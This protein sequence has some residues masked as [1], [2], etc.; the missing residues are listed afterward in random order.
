MKT[1][2][3]M[4]NKINYLNDLLPQIGYTLLHSLWGVTIVVL[5]TIG[6]I[7]IFKMT[8]TVRHQLA[9]AAQ[10]LSFLLVLFI[11]VYSGPTGKTT[12]E[13][14]IT[15]AVSYSEASGQ[16]GEA[17][18]LPALNRAS[19][20][21]VSSAR[22][23]GIA[24]FVGLLLLASFRIF[25]YCIS[26][27]M[28]KTGLFTVTDY[29]QDRLY[30]LS[31]SS[32]IIRKVRIHLSTKVQ[33]PVLI[34]YFKP[35]ILV[36]LGFFGELS[37]RE[38]ESILLHELAHIKRHDYLHLLIQQTINMLLFY[39]PAI[40]LLSRV[41]DQERENAC[42]D[43]VLAV[44]GDARTYARALGTMQ[45]NYSKT[46]NKMAMNLLNDKNSVL[47]RLRRL[48]GE[49]TRLQWS[50]RLLILPALILISGLLLAFAPS[51]D[52]ESRSVHQSNNDELQVAADTS[53][54]K[55]KV[56]NKVPKN[57]KVKSR[58]KDKESLNKKG[59]NKQAEV[60]HFEEIVE[61]EYESVEVLEV[62][63]EEPL[64]VIVEE[65]AEVH[66]NESDIEMVVEE[67]LAVVVEE[68]SDVDN[69]TV[70]KGYVDSRLHPRDT[71]PTQMEL[72]REQLR[73][74]IDM[75]R[76]EMANI[77]DEKD[78]QMT[79]ERMQKKLAE[80]SEIINNL[81]RITSESR[82][83]RSVQ[84]V[85]MESQ[86]ALLEAQQS[87]I[88]ARQSKLQAEARR[89]QAEALRGTARIHDNNYL[90]NYKTL[91]GIMD[92]D[93]LMM[94]YG[95]KIKLKV[96][97]DD[98]YLDGAKLSSKLSWKYKSLLKDY[99]GD[100]KGLVKIELLPDSTSVTKKNK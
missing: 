97:G 32:G 21:G 31:I 56:K 3:L 42:D 95:E 96:D 27:R 55:E 67:P 61:E 74:N 7:R 25:S 70:Y 79:A 38:V 33:S 94:K 8:A 83:G 37:P 40:W 28:K 44:T 45:L 13:R 64:E 92:N 87:I 98:V 65:V 76:E 14:Q 12:G 50:T 86:K 41:I 35:M 39:H 5:I 34:G 57:H 91:H 89:V 18:V 68:E 73:Q 62:I 52:H 26:R 99:I 78:L 58:R 43:Y 6:I 48:F 63:V 47:Q 90:L 16:V 17:Q 4:E 24:W 2:L 66:E 22:L 15:E 51:D 75:L 19:W 93:G 84:K 59:K 85:F 54:V 49:E 72:E 46:Q 77:V 53:I 29:W 36:P 71:V 23:L 69:T 81:E 100:S 30:Q 88:E 60:L 20:Y 80:M 11:F 9:A 1:Q 82:E 10:V